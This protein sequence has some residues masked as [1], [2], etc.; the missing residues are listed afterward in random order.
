MATLAP[1]LRPL[2]TE[3][4]IHSA[5][6]LSLANL[7]HQL[8][9]R[10]AAD[11]LKLGYDQLAEQ[12]R[13]HD[14]QLGLGYAGLNQ[15]N[16]AAALATQEKAREDRQRQN[17]ANFNQNLAGQKFTAQEKGDAEKAAF[18][19]QRQNDLTNWRNAQGARSQQRID[20]AGQWHQ[21]Q[22]GHWQQTFDANQTAAILKQL[23]I[24][25]KNAAG[26][27][28]HFQGRA[29]RVNPDGTS[30]PLDTSAILP[31]PS[32]LSL[33]D[34]GLVKDRT[35]QINE[36]QKDRAFLMAHPAND[37]PAD[38]ARWNARWNEITDNIG[39]L[40]SWN[41][42][43]L[44]K[45]EYQ[46]KPTIP[47]TPAPAA[48]ALS[49]APEGTTFPAPEGTTFNPLTNQSVAPSILPDVWNQP[50]DTTGSLTPPESDR[51]GAAIPAA[52]ALAPQY[53]PFSSGDYTGTP[54][55]PA[56]LALGTEANP[57]PM[58]NLGNATNDTGEGGLPR[59]TWNPDTQQLEPQ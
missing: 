25:A 43:T 22:N 40:Q 24:E 18:A 51:G 58:S 29:L 34:A 30:T 8:E 16:A 21:D 32:K 27:I 48:A 17:N 9:A 45:P 10:R 37:D 4:I 39:K 35:R 6:A 41:R 14:A 46:A 57:L 53:D 49:P 59:Y 2:D 44:A 38:K 42:E 50:V 33:T 36:L 26:Q 15:H 20:M 19:L 52:A 54:L 23:N 1:W 13:Q 7:Q 11:Q 55:D 56:I 47:T 28:L 12:A 3:G 5:A 31:P